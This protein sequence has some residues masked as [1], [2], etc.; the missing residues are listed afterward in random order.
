[1][2]SR[3]IPVAL[4]LFASSSSFGETGLPG[5][6]DA[7][8]PGAEV[9]QVRPGP[10]EEPITDIN[11]FARPVPNPEND[12]IVGYAMNNQNY[13][14]NLSTGQ[15][16]KIPDKSDAVATPDGRYMTVPSYYTPDGFVRFYDNEV[17]LDHLDKGKDAD[18]V[19]PVF[20]HEH[21]GTRQGFYQSL[22][23]VRQEHG[24]GGK[25]D[26]YRM[27]FSER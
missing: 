20:I 7:E 27:M 6:C 9:L 21:E 22:G 23:H 2:N 12:W 1:M 19:E 11:W 25:L 10:G 15:R 18:Q 16:I 13:L 8:T 5:F 3:H 4:L 24:D 26:V 14:Y 17:L